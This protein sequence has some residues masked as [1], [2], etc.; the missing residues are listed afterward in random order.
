MRRLE[1]SWQLPE[2]PACQDASFLHY[3]NLRYGVLLPDPRLRKYIRYYWVLRASGQDSSAASKGVEPHVG[4]LIIP[5][6]YGEIV[7]NFADG[8]WRGRVGLEKYADFQRESYVVGSRHC[9]VRTGS[10][11]ELNMV[12]V[13]LLPTVLHSIIGAS[14]GKFNNQALSLHELN[15]AS[16][17]DLE[18]KLAMINNTQFVKYE[19]DQFFLQQLD[20]KPIIDA[21]VKRAIQRIAELKGVV[22][23]N[24]L[25]AD[26]G[27][28]YKTLERRFRNWVGIS[29]KAFARVIRFKHSYHYY[30]INGRHDNKQYLDFGYYDQSHFIKEFKYFIGATPTELASNRFVDTT[31]ISDYSLKKDLAHSNSLLL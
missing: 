11:G 6:G 8:F 15:F 22:S 31:A 27:T 20:N 16:L 13:K 14:L 7:L 4:Q 24:S 17:C 23:I 10:W 29:P 26:L 21:V 25:I 30:R 3:R 9:S 28:N 19:L 1:S 2:Q 12:G 5:D 18:N